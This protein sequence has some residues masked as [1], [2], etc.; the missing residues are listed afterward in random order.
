MCV[1]SFFL[2]VAL[3][4]GTYPEFCLPWSLH[5]ALL[6]FTDMSWCAREKSKRGV[7]ESW[8]RQHRST[9]ADR[10]N[11]PGILFQNQSFLF[12]KHSPSAATMKSKK[13]TSPTF[14][15]GLFGCTPSTRY[16]HLPCL[17]PPCAF[18]IAPPQNVSPR[19]VSCHKRLSHAPKIWSTGVKE[20]QWRSAPKETT[21]LS[22]SARVYPQ[23][24][25]QPTARGVAEDRGAPPPGRG[26]VES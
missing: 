16:P 24:I 10:K 19:S 25:V 4:A 26:S 18:P 5:E 7:G 15:A 21:H 8:T 14:E 6:H 1:R 17:S 12:Q 22:R 23:A 9:D 2:P 20:Q 13:L 3:A 11:I